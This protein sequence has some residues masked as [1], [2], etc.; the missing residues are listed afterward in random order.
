MKWILPIF[1]P[2]LKGKE[3]SHS[4]LL[5]LLHELH[6]KLILLA[7]FISGPVHPILEGD[8][9]NSLALRSDEDSHCNNH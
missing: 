3:N 9:L 8:N 6:V 2:D 5:G 1:T 7:S 4:L